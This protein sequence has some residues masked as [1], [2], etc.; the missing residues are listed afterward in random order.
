MRSGI[1]Y[2]DDHNANLAW[3]RVKDNIP[4]QDDVVVLAAVDRW[5]NNVK[6]V[7]SEELYLDPTQNR[8]DFIEGF[9][10]SHPNCFFEVSVVD[11]PRFKNTY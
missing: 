3:I 2:I 10:G 9:V 5:H 8:V 7:S 1:L 6:H 4:G 11:L